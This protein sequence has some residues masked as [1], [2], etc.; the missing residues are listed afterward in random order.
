M[1]TLQYPRSIS[2]RHLLFAI[3]GTLLLLTLAI[4]VWLLTTSGKK[5]VADVVR[6]AA[7]SSQVAVTDE[8]E[9]FLAIGESANRQLTLALSSSRADIDQPRSLQRLIRDV[10]RVSELGSVSN[11][12]IGL[13]DGRF[14][15]LSAQPSAWPTLFWMHTESSPGTDGRLT[16]HTDTNSGE[17]GPVVQVYEEYDPRT[18]PWYLDAMQTNESIWTGV[19]PNFGTNT[20]TITR[21]V[22]LRDSEGRTIGVAGADLFIP[23][24][25]SFLATLS[26]SANSEVFVL[27]V[28]GDPIAAWGPAAGEPALGQPPDIPFDALRFTPLA[29]E[30]VN[31]VRDRYRVGKDTQPPVDNRDAQWLAAYGYGEPGAPAA[32]MPSL[33]I[34]DRV[35][36]GATNVNGESGFLAVATLDATNTPPWQVGVFVPRS[37]YLGSVSEQVNRVVPL[38]LLLTLFTLIAI[39]GF[40]ALVSRPLEKLCASVGLLGEGRFNEPVPIPLGREVGT[41]ARAFDDMRTK[42]GDSFKS[43]DAERQRATATLQSIEDGVV[44]ID[45]DNNV[46]LLNKAAERITGHAQKDVLNAALEDVL[47][48]RDARSG[49]RFTSE[50]LQAELASSRRDGV[51]IVVAPEFGVELQVRLTAT[52]LVQGDDS[53]GAVL[54]LHDRTL[55]S[56]LQNELAWA[57]SHDA[58]TELVNRREL[59]ERIARAITRAREQQ[60]P[61][62]L[63]FI[64]LVDFSRI[65]TE[66][67][68]GGGDE[69]LRQIAVLL[70]REAEAQPFATVARIGG[71]EFAVLVE[72]QDVKSTMG[73]FGQLRSSV[74][75]FQFSW[76]DRGFTVAVS[77]GALDL[78]D[79]T[80]GPAA[81]LH[82]AGTA[83]LQAREEGSFQVREFQV[84]EDLSSTMELDRARIKNAMSEKRFELVAQKVVSLRDDKQPDVE[85]LVRLRDEA[86]ELLLPA[87]F[88]PA[89]ERLGIA[90][91]LD[92]HIIELTLSALAD[93]SLSVRGLQSCAIN[94]S[95]Q[96]LGDPTFLPWI[97][98]ALSRYPVDPRTLTFE[99]TET[100]TVTHL[101]IAKR[102]MQSLSEKG[103]QFSLDD[104][105]TGLCSFAYLKELPIN[106]LKIDGSFVMG[107]MSDW[108]SETLVRSMIELGKSLELKIV[109]EC[110]EDEPTLAALRAMGVD[111][112]Q[113]FFLHRPERF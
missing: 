10:E 58:L 67:G 85:I 31:A 61:S 65:N 86:G 89:A 79:K 39:A 44:V 96:T 11:I 94:L 62:A 56:Q 82:D 48:A 23:H 92:R 6:Q 72:G 100:A 109:A 25:Q 76:I 1:P 28:E 80:L 9:H 12:Y 4:T 24:L 71:D 93:S 112:A 70:L 30:Q 99:V 7:I 63:A 59:V 19:Y 43:L 113:G 74:A 21:A 73:F 46:L 18:R 97:L 105:G 47:L 88:L 78:T 81:A 15:G 35:L 22:K 20:P 52:E 34:Q 27:D 84:D 45:R 57:A 75:Q 8:L 68:Y 41:L 106:G 49:Q 77:V 53:Q 66:I 38:A 90:N 111:K 55:A 42:L 60:L 54:T 5:I 98:D 108:R 2:A 64:D 110:I 50:S 32:A 40:A 29:V 104:F 17:S 3:Y 26:L 91:K 16:Y 101:S 107:M 33:S 103:V 83:S 36:S 37:D 87:S 13:E 51:E 14:Y 69:L 95:G 102:L